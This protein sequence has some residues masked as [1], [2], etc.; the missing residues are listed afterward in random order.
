M[1]EFEFEGR[2]RNKELLE[3]GSIIEVSTCPKTFELI[4]NKNIILL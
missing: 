4:N 1:L 3:N 2:L